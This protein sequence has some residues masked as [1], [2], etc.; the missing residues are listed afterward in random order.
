[1][2]RAPARATTI[3][4]RCRFRRWERCPTRHRVAVHMRRGACEQRCRE[5]VGRRL[6]KA[7]N[8]SRLFLVQLGVRS[9]VRAE[10]RRS[11]RPLGLAICQC[12]HRLGHWARWN[13]HRH[14]QWRGDV[15]RAGL[16]DGSR[17]RDAVLRQRHDRVGG[18]SRWTILKTTDGGATWT[19]QV[20]GAGSDYFYKVDF[21]DAKASHLNNV[22][23]ASQHPLGGG[24]SLRPLM[25][26]LLRCEH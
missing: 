25:P 13:D 3:P 21:V 18:G 10:G 12:H 5:C 20:S 15:D 17:H 9:V 22:G 16:R 26:T 2:P 8:H 14:H 1:M 24:P 11:D 4:L 6:G 23:T 19:A 7:H